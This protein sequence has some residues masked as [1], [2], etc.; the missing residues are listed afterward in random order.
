MKK[1]YSDQSIIESIQAGGKT[2]ESAMRYLYEQSE[3]R[4]K[5]LQFV[6]LKNGSDEDGEDVF[7][8]GISHLVMN[9][10][11]GVFRGES[12]LQTYLM[13]I[14]K[15]LWFYKFNRQVK[16]N[17]IKKEIPTPEISDIETPEKILIYK[18]RSKMV[19]VILEKIGSPCKEI[20]SLWA[21]SYSMKEMAGKL[22]YKNEGSMR[23]KKHQC[24]KKI[25]E[26][27]KSQSSLT[28]QVKENQ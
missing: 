19:K 21:L 14:C 6:R 2:M 28:Q 25:M 4:K 1:T 8:D 17:A 16:L 15:K 5:V 20:L 9:I 23:K 7:Q 11:K 24:Q 3:I 26:L 10:R 12:S 13:V 22:G 27:I 18:E